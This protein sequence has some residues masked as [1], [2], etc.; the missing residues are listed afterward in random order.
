MNRFDTSGIE[1]KSNFVNVDVFPPLEIIPP[2]V[3]L[4]P[5]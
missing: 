4:M 1:I 3:L 2:E 5:G